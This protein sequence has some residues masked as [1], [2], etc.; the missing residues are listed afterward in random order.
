MA[1]SY[2]PGEVARRLSADDLVVIDVR[3]RDEWRDAQVEGASHLP[4]DEL[5]Q[6][7]DELPH[8]RPIAFICRTG[9]RSETAA[10]RAAEQG[11]NAGNVTGGIEAWA[12]A[13]LPVRPGDAA[14]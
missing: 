10:E 5:D 7:S 2:E 1:S 12:K 13:G 6:R 3:D 9:K 4:L 11:L 8:D 14:A